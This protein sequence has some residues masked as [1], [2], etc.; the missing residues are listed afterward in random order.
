MAQSNSLE[1]DRGT[2]KAAGAR[3]TV[4]PCSTHGRSRCLDVG[5]GFNRTLGSE[6]QAITLQ[7]SSAT[8]AAD[9]CRRVIASPWAWPQPTGSPEVEQTTTCHSSPTAVGFYHRASGPSKS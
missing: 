2:M 1:S 3:E 4:L 9:F 8:I 6:T 7:I 5:A